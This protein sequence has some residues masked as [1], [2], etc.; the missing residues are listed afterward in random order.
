[1]GSPYYSLRAIVRALL[2]T[3][4]PSTSSA[5]CAVA[6]QRFS[7]QRSMPPASSLF[8]LSSH[9]K[10][11]SKFPIPTPALFEHLSRARSLFGAGMG[12][13]AIELL[14]CV[15]RATSGMQWSPE[16]RMADAL[17]IVDADIAQCIQ[18]C[19]EQQA[20][21]GMKDIQ[22]ARAAL[23]DIREAMSD[24][25]SEVESWGGEFPF[26]R[27]MANAECLTL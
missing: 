21:G 6:R 7:S 9:P 8:K 11:L 27:G 13:E 22:G 20:G 1:M 10:N 18:A 5:F 12:I 24:C 3:G 17:C 26:E 14:T 23:D 15:V 19:K 4:P 16:G 2:A 25:Q